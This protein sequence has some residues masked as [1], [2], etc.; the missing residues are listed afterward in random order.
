V[1]LA[2][3]KAKWQKTMFATH[4]KR[5]EHIRELIGAKGEAL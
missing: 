3:G 4:L 1:L 5:L 2:V